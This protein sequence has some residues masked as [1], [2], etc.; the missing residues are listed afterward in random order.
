MR[1][2]ECD[3]KLEVTSLDESAT[4]WVNGQEL[5]KVDKPKR[6]RREYLIASSA[7]MVHVGRNV[8]AIQVMP[9]L[10]NQEVLLDARLDEIRRPSDR[11]GEVAEKPVTQ[12]A[13][14]C[15]LCSSLPSGPACVHA[16]PHEAAM[17]VN[18]R[19]G[20]GNHAG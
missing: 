6:G 16:C 3:F 14:V 9:A 20:F 2:R 11:G 5:P 4:V 18:A 19:S 7:N 12:L 1:R 8:L 13:V 10:G 15:D 17:R